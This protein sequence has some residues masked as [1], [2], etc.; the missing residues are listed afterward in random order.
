MSQVLRTTLRALMACG[1]LCA[2]LLSAAGVR[3]AG[4]AASENQLSIM[5]DDD[6]LIYRSDRTR[7]ATLR[8]MKTLGVD[9]VRVTLLWS[10]VAEEA[11]STKARDQRFRRLGAEN[12]K[13]YPAGTWDRYDRLARAVR[14]LG[15]QLYFDVTGPGP[16]Y[17]H[18]KPPRKYRKDAKWWRPKPREYYKFVQAV[19]KRF[20]GTYND[21]NDGRGAIPRVS[22]W[23]I[24]NEP[25]QGGWLRPQWLGGKPVSPQI[26][27]E[28]FAFGRRALVSTGH[29]SDT[30]LVGET[31]P[32]A[33]KRRTTTSAMGV[34]TFANELLCGPGHKGAG[35]G[36]FEKD[37]PI[38]ASAWAHHPYTRTLAPNVREGGSN[39]ITL[40]NLKDLG[41]LL[42]QLSATGNIKS[43]LP[44]MSTEFGY[45]T[46]PPDPF[47]GVN[48]QQQAD[49]LALS[50]LI[51][52]SNPRVAA[53]TQF[54]LRDVAPLTRF[55]EGSRDYWST[56][57][58][59]L[60]TQRDTPKPAA[61]AYAFPFLAA[62]GAPKPGTGQPQTVVFG[63]IR[64]RE[65]IPP[66]QTPDTVQLQFK[67]ANGSSDW[68]SFDAPIAT[69]RL[70][71]FL[72]TVVTPGPG[73]IRAIWKGGQAPFSISAGKPV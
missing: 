38:V 47:I 53:H 21:E 26:Y 70:G 14:T 51:T 10:V 31:A 1:A 36:R 57:Q 63:Q 25:N 35:C 33:V 7:D 3:P 40:A 72:S 5:M 9:T 34:R 22:F 29:G 49:Y 43:G 58:S 62:R 13:S 64:F 54:L 65:N 19:G 4:A 2:L 32:R 59:G 42:D 66:G 48:E 41:T 18:T 17:A 24:W 55:E 20:S 11:R 23:S 15:M 61:Q 56:Y 73:Q 30:I 52:Y 16:A 68:A 44:L 71:Y 46:K 60:Y 12:P 8:R 50:E 27:R 6:L 39:S 69:T 37:G 67:P 45:E 28:L